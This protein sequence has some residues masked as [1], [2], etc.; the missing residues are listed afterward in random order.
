MMSF[1]YNPD[2]TC[3]T[4]LNQQYNDDKGIC[5]DMAALA[6]TV[7]VECADESTK[8]ALTVSPQRAT[9]GSEFSVT[10]PGSNIPDTIE[11]SVSD[12]V[13]GTMLQKN[14]IRTTGPLHLKE[15]YGALQVQACD[16]QVCLQTT[17]LTHTVRNEGD[18]SMTVAA[19]TRELTGVPT[20]DLVSTLSV[21]PIPMGVS[22]TATETLGLDICSTTTIDIAV[23]VDALPDDGPECDGLDRYTINIEPVC[24]LDVD[25]TCVEDSPSGQ[26]CGDFQAIGDPPCDCSGECATDLSFIYTG[27]SCDLFGTD[28]FIDE[29]DNS[30]TP[31]PD[32]VL[33]I[34]ETTGGASVFS[35]VVSVGDLV[36]FAA[37]EGCLPDV[38]QITVRNP[39]A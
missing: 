36:E 31:L 29:C 10:N 37:D 13:T 23:D 27:Q 38:F 17:I 6:E 7:F 34:A 30:G 2:S 19:L 8:S 25:L 9:R 15:T 16:D 4:S 12:L 24:A 26:P 35:D 20:V 3:E 22:A 1:T 11:C 21:N 28:G 33:L 39:H 14:V 18:S 32:S 5:E